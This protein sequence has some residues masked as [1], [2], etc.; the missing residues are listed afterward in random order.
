MMDDRV[1]NVS[2][3]SNYIPY[4]SDVSSSSRVVVS[5][6]SNNMPYTSDI[7]LHPPPGLV[8]QWTF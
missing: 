7:S 5:D 4:T 6:T 8:S 2:D 3:T 1:I